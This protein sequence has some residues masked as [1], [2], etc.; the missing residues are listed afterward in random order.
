MSVA[1][2]YDCVTRTP[3]GEQ[4]SLFTVRIDGDGFTGLNEGTLGSMEISDGRID[5][6]R[7]DW[8]MQMTSPMPM[9]LVC[10]AVIEG[11]TLTGNV[12]AGG[13]GTMPM[14]GTRI[15]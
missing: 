5:G 11:D 14:N 2:T 12:K 3:L 15:G 7:L 6:N 8:T 13:F 4:K 1:G 10:D 9:M